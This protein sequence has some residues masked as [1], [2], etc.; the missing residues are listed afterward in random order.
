MQNN[1][2][3]KKGQRVVATDGRYEARV[4]QCHKDGSITIRQGFCLQDGEP[5][6][7]S[8]LNYKHRISPALVQAASF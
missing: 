6:P 1:H 7:G 2:S 4:E 3:F 5:V 8:F